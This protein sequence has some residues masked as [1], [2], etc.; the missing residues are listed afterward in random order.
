MVRHEDVRVD[1]YVIGRGSQ[2]QAAE[3]IETVRILEEDVL[4]VVAAH[5]YV[6]RNAGNET[7]PEP[8]HAG[9]TGEPAGGGQVWGQGRPA[10]G[11]GL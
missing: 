3:E 10:L 1:R 7:S 4:A 8:G 6:L 2:L 11:Q 9:A 5:H